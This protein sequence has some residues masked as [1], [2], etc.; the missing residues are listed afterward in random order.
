MPAQGGGIGRRQY[1]A[2]AYLHMLL[3]VLPKYSIAMTNRLLKVQ[4]C[5]SYSSSSF[6]DEGDS[7]GA[8]VLG[9]WLLCKPA[10]L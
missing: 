8:L 2:G 10:G 6:E 7:F 1:V 3:S 4:E 5:H 9:S